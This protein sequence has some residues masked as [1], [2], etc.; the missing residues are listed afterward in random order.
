[1]FLS[2]FYTFVHFIE[3]KIQLTFDFTFFFKNFKNQTLTFSLIEIRAQIQSHQ[4]STLVTRKL[5]R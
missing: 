4:F 2:N 3:L 1:M 5:Q